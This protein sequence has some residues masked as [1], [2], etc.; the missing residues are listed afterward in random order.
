MATNEEIVY[1]NL[2]L[3]HTCIDCQ[4]AKLKD[5]GKQQFKEDLYQDIIIELLEYSQ[6]KLNNAWENNHLN[7]LVTKIIIN[8]I[9]SC[10]SKFY[11]KYLKFSIKSNELDAYDENTDGGICT[12]N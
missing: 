7:A 5:P 3:I 4:F 8:N 10:T 9:Y 11:K 6:E 1:G 12:T 2:N